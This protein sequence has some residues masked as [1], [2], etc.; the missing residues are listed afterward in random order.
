MEQRNQ[1]AQLVGNAHVVV[2]GT[3]GAALLAALGAQGV[4]QVGRSNVVDAAT[5][6]DGGVVVAIAGQGEC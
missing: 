4:T 1:L 5:E 3:P 6:A 2:A